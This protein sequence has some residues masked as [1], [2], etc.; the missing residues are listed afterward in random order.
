MSD[1]QAELTGQWNWGNARRFILPILLVVLLGGA[2]LL[3]I[4]GS[5]APA[6]I[7]VTGVED[8][9]E[10][11]KVEP[12]EGTDFSWVFLTERAAER[13]DIK[14]VLL[15]EEEVD[16]EQRLVVPYSAVI[17]GLN[18]ETWVYVGPETLTYVRESITV[19]YIEGDLVIL[20]D[21]PA[22]GTNVVTVGVPEL[23]GAETGVG[24]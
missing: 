18:G 13:L 22:V 1:T 15:R 17:Y 10:P 6:T 8:Q 12:I 2:A 20:S 24:K 3:V 16:G 4:A 19:D 9:S 14:T 5:D 7:P 21:G 23:Y 11:A